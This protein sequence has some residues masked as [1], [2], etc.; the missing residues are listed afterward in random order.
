MN[1]RHA[2]VEELTGIPGV[3]VPE[4]YKL[5]TP[6][7][8][9]VRSSDSIACETKKHFLHEARFS[10]EAD[11]P[12]L[13]ALIVSGVLQRVRQR[14]LLRRHNR[15]QLGLEQCHTRRTVKER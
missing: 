15:G 8:V 10:A 11:I 9:H 7:T 6:I 4:R 2:I 5:R 13:K 14:N 12:K 3:I 1:G